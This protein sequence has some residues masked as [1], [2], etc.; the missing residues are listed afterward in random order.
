M[1]DLIGN[2]E[3]RFSK[4]AASDIPAHEIMSRVMRKPAFCIYIC[5]NKA[6]DQLCGNRTADL[7][8]CC[9]Y[10]VSS[11]PL[12]SKFQASNHLLWLHS[13]GCVGPG[14]KP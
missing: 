1:S 3:D 14:R 11:I 12:L 6:A 7:R 10:V 8:L 9:R 2:T 13:Q 5:E 4:K